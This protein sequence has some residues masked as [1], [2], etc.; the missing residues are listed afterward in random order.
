MFKN[1]I[2]KIN[3][4]GYKLTYHQ[5]VRIINKLIL[6]YVNEKKNM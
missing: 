3:L 6:Y 2:D 1:L 5:K 4:I